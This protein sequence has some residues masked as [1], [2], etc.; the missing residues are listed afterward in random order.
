M[1]NLAKIKALLYAAGDQGIT[2]RQI[3]QRASLSVAACRQLIEKIAESFVS[4]NDCGLQVLISNDV[5]RLGTKSELADLV[6]DYINDAKP[7]V[8]SQAALE[9]ISIIMYNQPITRIEIDEIRGVNSAAIIHRLINQGLV[10]MVGVKQEVGNP[11]QYGATNF[12]LDYFGLTSLADLPE[13]PKDEPLDDNTSDKLLTRFN[14]EI[15]R[16]DQEMNK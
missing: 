13:L 1:S 2:L 7:R 9:T 4:D 14:K 10:E 5:Y 11:K 15:D 6:D 16:H 12:C 8:L 3:A